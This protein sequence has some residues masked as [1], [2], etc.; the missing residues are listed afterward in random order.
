MSTSQRQLVFQLSQVELATMQATD[1]SSQADRERTEQL[2]K[3]VR[4]S[5]LSNPDV[6]LFHQKRNPKMVS[7]YGFV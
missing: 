3:M 5:T 7:T 6:F 2:E 4:A 1:V